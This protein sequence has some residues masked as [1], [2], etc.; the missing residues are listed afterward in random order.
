MAPLVE[1][2]FDKHVQVASANGKCH[3]MR[4]HPNINGHDVSQVLRGNSRKNDLVTAAQNWTFFLLL[5][6][7]LALCFMQVSML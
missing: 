1:D 2:S 7:R 4:F 6:W 5:P 3:A